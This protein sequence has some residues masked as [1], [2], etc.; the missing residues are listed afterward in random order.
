MF[1]S[2][3][4]R[5]DPNEMEHLWDAEELEIHSTDVQLTNLWKFCVNLREFATRCGIHGGKN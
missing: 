2:G 1:F 4:P 3:L 5:P